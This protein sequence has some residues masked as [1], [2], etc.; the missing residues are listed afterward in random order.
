LRRFQ[1]SF[2]CPPLQELPAPTKLS[3]RLK[4]QMLYKTF[5]VNL[6]LDNPS[7]SQY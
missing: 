4:F 6:K 7:F 2:N 3:Y 1:L 5:A